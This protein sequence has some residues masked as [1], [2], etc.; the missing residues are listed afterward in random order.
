MYNKSLELNQAVEMHNK[1]LALF[2]AIGATPMV[3][4]VQGWLDELQGT[5]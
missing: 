1:S 5:K 2:Q 3:E 4:K